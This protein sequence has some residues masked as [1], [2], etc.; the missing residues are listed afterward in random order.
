[1]KA[2]KRLKSIVDDTK[3]NYELDYSLLKKGKKLSYLK[4]LIVLKT[5]KKLIL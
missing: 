2:F 1:M 3:I 4:L 5:I